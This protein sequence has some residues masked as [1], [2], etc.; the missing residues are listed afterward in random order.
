MNEQAPITPSS[1]VCNV[2]P[3][4]PEKFVVDLVN[5]LDVAHD[6]I[7]VQRRRDR[8]LSRMYDGFTGKSATRQMEINSNLANSIEGTLN[9]LT[10]L[11]ESVTQSNYALERANKRI[12]ELQENV[13][14]IANYAVET[15]NQLNE[16]A[17]KISL[18]C[19]TLRD[20]INRVDFEQ[21]AER[22][23]TQVFYKW[24]AGH[25]APFSLLG[26][27]YAVLEELRWG[28]FGAYCQNNNNIT[29]QGFLEQLE[30]MATV[31]VRKDL[32]LKT[33]SSV[34]NAEVWV[35]PTLERNNLPDGQEAL[36]YL[37]NW[38]NPES[39]PFVY[40]TTQLPD[41]PP[42]FL[43]RLFPSERATQ[44]MV[45]EIFEVF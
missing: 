41:A 24:E 10:I 34:I 22:Q 42:L 16:M 1:E 37:G 31:Q 27:V 15:R 7:R 38:S 12:G 11:T 29:R 25:F 14:S 17:R 26:R 33:T 40:M 45:S 13:A 8:F 32:Q 4:L 5:G 19:E 20:E 18:R 23:L 3:C 2:L 36:A 35:A 43:P 28:A 9:L 6:H 21:Q 39:H 44:A 30:N